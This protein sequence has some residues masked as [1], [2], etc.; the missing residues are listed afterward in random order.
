MHVEAGYEVNLQMNK[1]ITDCK[2]S[3]RRNRGPVKRAPEF[4]LKDIDPLKWMLCCYGP[5]RTARPALSYAWMPMGSVDAERDR[6]ER[7]E[8]EGRVDQ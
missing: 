6:S 5:R 2:R 4:E 7:H 1:L 3:L 8:M